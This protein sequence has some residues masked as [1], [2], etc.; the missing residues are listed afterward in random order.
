VRATDWL[1]IGGT[2]LRTHTDSLLATGPILASH[3]VARVAGSS[4][5]HHDVFA[6]FAGTHPKLTLVGV[7]GQVV[8]CKGQEDRSQWLSIGTMVWPFYRK[9]GRRSRNQKVG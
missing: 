9:Q 5:D 8:P 3:I 6:L 2:F 4:F 1:E 7:G